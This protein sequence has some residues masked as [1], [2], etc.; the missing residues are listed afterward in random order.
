MMRLKGKVMP[1]ALASVIE[2]LASG[3]ARRTAAG[4]AMYD[5]LAHRT[6]RI[7]APPTSMPA[8]VPPITPA[9]PATSGKA[10]AKT[11]NPGPA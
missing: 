4:A 11:T 5:A 7:M 9:N 2:G 10:M 6:P 8:S 1:S 3:R